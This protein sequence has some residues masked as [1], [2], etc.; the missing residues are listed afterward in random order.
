MLHVS[1]AAHAYRFSA[2]TVFTQARTPNKP[3]VGLI[4]RPGIR[5]EQWWHLWRSGF[6][7]YL[8]AHL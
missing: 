2:I 1:N 8:W 4:K 3:T 7:C 5:Q 6:R